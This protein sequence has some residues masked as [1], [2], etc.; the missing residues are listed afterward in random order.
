MHFRTGTI[1]AINCGATFSG[2]LFLLMLVT[3]PIVVAIEPTK[4]VTENSLNQFSNKG[5]PRRVAIDIGHFP[6]PPELRGAKGFSG[7]YEY[8]YNKA[9]AEKIGALLMADGI[10]VT[11]TEGTL[12][13]RPRKA[14]AAKV[15]LFVSIH[16]DSV[17]EYRL[18]DAKLPGNR[19]RG[20]S[21]F[22]S[23]LNPK[24]KQSLRCASEVG[25]AMNNIKRV[26]S[27]YHADKVPGEHKDFL[28][29]ANGV[30]RY[31]G[32]AVMKNT[33][34]PA[35]LFEAGVIVNPEDEQVSIQQRD[36][37]AAAMKDAIR[38][39]LKTL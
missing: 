33:T 14:A 22:V 30:H 5:K 7:T 6:D 38:R 10:E 34:M 23:K 35:L 17:Q 21:V 11:Y 31:D 37:M 9:L 27:L 39:C 29:E 1:K 19:Y 4:A 20:Y 28:D 3:T 25:K 16:H 26:R 18:E 32:L 12:G 13:E 2:L 8:V 24:Y 36:A 15:E